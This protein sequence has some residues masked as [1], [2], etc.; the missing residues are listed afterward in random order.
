MGLPLTTCISHMLCLI[1]Q[2]V[3]VT[4]VCLSFRRTGLALFLEA[5]SVTK[6]PAWLYIVGGPGKELE[7]CGP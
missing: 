3:T 6:C 1:A 5:S 4:C 7:V 2:T